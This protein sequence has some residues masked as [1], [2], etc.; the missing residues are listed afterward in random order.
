M[1]RAAALW[2][3]FRQA[4]LSAISGNNFHYLP[5]WLNY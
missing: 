5:A 2:R 3:A 4:L 1:T